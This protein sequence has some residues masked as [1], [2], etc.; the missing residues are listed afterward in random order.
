MPSLTAMPAGQLPMT[1]AL[2]IALGAGFISAVVF[3][4]ATT[5]PVLMRMVLFLLTPLALFLAGLG[6]G[7]MAGAVAALVGTLVVFAVG[8]VKV[9]LYFAASAAVPAILLSYLAS[10]NRPVEGGS[11]EWYP[12][13][14][15]VMVT[16]LIAGGFAALALILLGGD[17]EALRTNLRAALDQLVNVQLEAVPDAPK[18]GPKELDELTAL[19]LVLLPAG[20]AMWEMT[21]VLFNFWLAG[22]ITLA[23]GRLRRPWPDLA[24]LSYPP[25]MPLLLAISTAAG[26][27][28][29][30]PGLIAAGFAGPLFFAYVLAGISVVHYVTRGSTW[31]VFQLS[32]LYASFL[33]LYPLAPLAIAL[34]GLVDAVWPVRK[35]A[36]ARPGPPKT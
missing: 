12:P 1:Y 18:L 2:L 23:S 20:L 32:A 13:G 35:L 8:G 29:G 9:G 16:A 10:L 28:G 17:T 30:L 33:L 11:T 25:V 24:T 4:S 3:A 7:P 27:L 19:A 26:F 15:M 31:R 36:A 14:R 6:L 34:L 21:A 5:G 22:R